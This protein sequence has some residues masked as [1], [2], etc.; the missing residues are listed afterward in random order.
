[1]IEEQMKT[2][3]TNKQKIEVSFCSWNHEW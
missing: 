2:T 1:V 3:K